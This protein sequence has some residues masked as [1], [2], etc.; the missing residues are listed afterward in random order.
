MF[1]ECVTLTRKLAGEDDRWR[2]WRVIV[3]DGS[4][5]SMP[6]TAELQNAFPQPTG[7][8]KGCGFP[9][10]RLVVLFDWRS[11]AVIDVRH[12]IAARQ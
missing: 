6:D 9:V 2:R 5:V 8:A 1:D 3:V 11:G 10:A 7:Q 4:S 12:G